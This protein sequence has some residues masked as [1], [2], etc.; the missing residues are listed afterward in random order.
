LYCNFE[1]PEFAIE[2]RVHEICKAMGIDV[3]KNL[4]LWNL[5]GHAADAATILPIISREAKRVGFMLIVLDPFY[6]LLGARDENAS[7]DMADLMN[8]IERVA[9]D[10]GG[11]VAFGSRFAKGNASAKESMDRISGSGVFARDPDSILTTT[12]HEQDDAFSVEM[13]LRNHAPQEP[14]VIRSWS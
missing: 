1:L 3:P 5:R 11:A 9:V 2:Q 4:T 8:Q 6:K 12:R 13:T 14:F 10:T 7:R